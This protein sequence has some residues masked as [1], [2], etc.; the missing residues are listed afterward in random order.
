[1][2]DHPRMRGE[3]ALSLPSG[4]YGAVDHPRMRGEDHREAVDVL[5]RAG[6]PPHARGRPAHS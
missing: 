2:R 5:A 4:W 1:M 6:S 3:D